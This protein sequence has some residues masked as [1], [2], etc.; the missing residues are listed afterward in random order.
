VFRTSRQPSLGNSERDEALTETVLT[1][2]DRHGADPFFAYIHLIGPHDPYDPPRA[3]VD[4]FRDPS[5]G[6]APRPT[7]P[8]G[9]VQS[10]FETAE[11][12]DE[13]TLKGLRAQYDGAIAFSDMLVGRIVDR[14]EKRGLL[15]RTLLVLVSD[16]GEEFYEHRNWRHG[17]QLYDEVIQVPMI[18][19]FPG[20]LEPERSKEP[21]ML[22]D[23]FPTVLGLLG[24]PNSLPT[25]DG[26]NAFD[27]ARSRQRP[28]FSE[29]WRFEGGEYVSRAVSRDGMKLTETNDA[30]QGKRDAELYDLQADPREQRNLLPA[31]AGGQKAAADLKALLAAFEPEK[32]FAVAPAVDVDRST[33]ER[34]RALGY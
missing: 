27:P 28:V 18:V 34:L 13:L 24:L 20:R 19:R 30:T 29:H 25:V 26:R 31:A 11:Q 21:V 17:N 23:V 15:D 22:V 3:F 1:W 9:R 2:L 8:P 33:E 16:H 6:D 14:L 5:F 12:L 10:I 4:R 7:K 32:P